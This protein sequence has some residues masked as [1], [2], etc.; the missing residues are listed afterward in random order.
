M[1]RHPLKCNRQYNF[2]AK[3]NKYWTER[4]SALA[5]A[6]EDTSTGQGVGQFVDISNAQ[7]RSVHSVLLPQGGDYSQGHGELSAAGTFTI[8]VDHRATDGAEGVYG[9]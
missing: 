9:G 5:V 2:T 3:K 6:G 8:T 4:I 7:R 1:T